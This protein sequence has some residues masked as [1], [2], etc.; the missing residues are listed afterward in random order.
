L[1]SSLVGFFGKIRLMNNSKIAEI[2]RRAW[3]TIVKQKRTIHPTKGRKEAELLGVFIKSLPGGGKVLDLGCGS[4]MPIGKK[5]HAEGL[6][7]VGVDVSD[8]MVSEYQKNVPEATTYRTPMT[9]INFNE[10]FDGVISSFSMLCLPPEDFSLVA[11]KAVLALKTSGWFFLLLNEGDSK[12]GA[13]QEVQGQ[14]MYST[15]MS[16]KEV[17]DIFEPQGMKITRVER[18]T[19][20]TKE[21]GTEYT[22][23]FLMQ[24]S[25]YVK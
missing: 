19:I 20:K 11:H 3:N 25:S 8:E 22:L 13:V 9:E 6:V 2:N 4:G 5:L 15:G 18:E 7:V 10:E 12:K 23:I 16:E 24:K 17:R 21:Y 1:K 14:Q